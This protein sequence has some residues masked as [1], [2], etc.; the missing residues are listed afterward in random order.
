LDSAAQIGLEFRF[1]ILPGLQGGLQRTNDRDIQFFAQYAVLSQSPRLPINVA[2]IGTIDGANNFKDSKSPAVGAIVSRTFSKYGAVY[3]EPVWV[4]NSNP[5]PN[6]LVDD[7]D[8]F[9]VGVGGRV[10]IR[11]NTYVVGEVIPRVN[12]FAPGVNNV[13]IGLEKHVGGHVFQINFEKG[14]GTTMT[15]IARGGPE[16]DSW[17][18]GFN[19]T[20]KFF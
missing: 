3:V 10:Q 14:F 4:N 16:S 17:F 19:I 11:K 15:Q 1:G 7:N 12:G 8:T 5:A 13:G 18:I 9:F 6:D 20:R 2:V